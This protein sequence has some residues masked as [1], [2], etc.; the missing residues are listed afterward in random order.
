MFR[1]MH[2]VSTSC[3]CRDTGPVGDF[4]TGDALRGSSSLKRFLAISM[5]VSGLFSTAIVSDVGG[6]IEEEE[7]EG[8]GRSREV[9]RAR[10]LL[11][12]C[13][14]GGRETRRYEVGEGAVR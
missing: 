1:Q 8:G 10:D 13:K 2:R 7:R 14:M 9:A 6:E 3:F 5:S 11:Y 4:C 12:V